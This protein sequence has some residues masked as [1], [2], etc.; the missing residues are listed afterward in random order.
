MLPKTLSTGQIISYKKLLSKAR[1]LATESKKLNLLAKYYMSYFYKL[2][3]DPHYKNLVDKCGFE[4]ASLRHKSDSKYSPAIRF[5]TEGYYFEHILSLKADVFDRDK[6][7]YGILE[8]KAKK[9][10]L[11]IKELKKLLS[12]NRYHLVFRGAISL[13]AIPYPN[14]LLSEP[15]IEIQFSHKKLLEK[16]FTE[17]VIIQ[18]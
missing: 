10:L 12:K 6:N 7:R 15:E 1:D 4:D 5:N 11:L 13:Y 16:Y 14:P 3:N 18:N 17:K 2:V 8:F 9:M